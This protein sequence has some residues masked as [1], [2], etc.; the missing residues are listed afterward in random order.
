MASDIQWSKLLLVVAC[1]AIVG[2]ALVF[3]THSTMPLGGYVGAMALAAWFNRRARPSMM[4]IV[5][6]AVGCGAIMLLAWWGYEH[7]HF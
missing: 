5:Y 2:T 7:L 4:R 3:I 6:A 1:A